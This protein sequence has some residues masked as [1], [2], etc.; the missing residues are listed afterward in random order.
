MISL[1]ACSS[2]SVESDDNISVESSTGESTKEETTTVEE[3]EIDI[4]EEIVQ[5]EPEST[6]AEL[7]EPTGIM[8]NWVSLTYEHK[9]AKIQECLDY[10]T[11][12]QEQEKAPIVILGTPEQFIEVIDA[13]YEEI[14]GLTGE[15]GFE[16]YRMNQSPVYM[17]VSIMGHST[18]LTK[19]WYEME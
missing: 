12:K 6:V 2:T 4:A 3:T 5:E 15:N 9:L 18:E 17:Q 11:K 10:W 8:E 13:R 14:Q 1:T 16:K 7:V 19:F